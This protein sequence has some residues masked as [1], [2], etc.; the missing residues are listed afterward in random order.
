MRSADGKAV[1][2][3]DDDNGRRSPTYEAP[4]QICIDAVAPGE[5]RS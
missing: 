3:T 5:K 4:R 2:D 1:L